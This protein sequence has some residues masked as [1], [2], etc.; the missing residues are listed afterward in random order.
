MFQPFEKMKAQYIARLIRLKMFYLVTQTYIRGIDHF[1]EEAR[2]SILVTD[3]DDYKTAETHLQ[4]IKTDKYASI[5]DLT[6]TS[7]LAKFQEMLSDDSKYN[8]FW[9]IVKDL[10][11]VKKRVDLKYKDNIRRYITKNTTWK[12][13][14]DE[15][16]RPQ[17]L[18]IFGEL[19]VIL[20]YR[21]QE[22][23]IKFEV[24]E[25]A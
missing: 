2:D 20:K 3:Y 25:K 4:S 6:K 8:I 22:R 13:G 1:A 23:R 17:L 10:E 12:I 18:V 14:G 15:T 19:F 7:H 11:L 21:S 9:A 16:V 24:I 5:I